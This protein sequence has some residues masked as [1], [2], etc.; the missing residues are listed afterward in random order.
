MN[1]SVC[2][3]YA[4]QL[5]NNKSYSKYDVDLLDSMLLYSEDEG[6]LRLIQSPNSSGVPH[7]QQ[8]VLKFQKMHYHTFMRCI[9]TSLW[10]EMNGSSHPLAGLKREEG[11]RTAY[12]SMIC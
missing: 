4:C 2:V 7:G 11:A 1:R 3:E 6:I 5:L 12:T 9:M 10:L 8:F